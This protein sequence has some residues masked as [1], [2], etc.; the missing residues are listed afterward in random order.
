MRN[1][2]RILIILSLV[3]P[4]CEHASAD[5][6]SDPNSIPNKTSSSTENVLTGDI[7]E[8]YRILKKK[9]RDSKIESMDFPGDPK[10]KTNLAESVKQIGDLELPEI[11]TAEPPAADNVDTPTTPE[12]ISPRQVTAAEPNSL[13]ISAKNARAA[14]D[15]AIAE[16]LAKPD[17]IAHPLAVAETL[18]AGHDYKNAAKFYEL[19]LQRM[20]QLEEQPD[21][22]WALFQAGNSNRLHDTDAA[23]KHYQT[24][25]EE[26]PNSPWTPAATVQL[27]IAQWPENDKPEIILDRYANDPNSL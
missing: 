11:K 18:Y 15:K 21:K 6:A 24:L 5:S 4:L 20:A 7:F 8:D 25:I 13:E 22:P 14:F 16:L 26:F 17:K 27:A 2:L 3:G 1:I 9:L 19:A 12:V 23:A 10:T